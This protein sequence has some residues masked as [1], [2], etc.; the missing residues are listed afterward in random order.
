MDPVRETDGESLVRADPPAVDVSV[1]IVSEAP[2]LRG[3]RR[4]EQAEQSEKVHRR[5]SVR[6]TSSRSY[7]HDGATVSQLESWEDEGGQTPLAAAPLPILIIDNDVSSASS[8]ELMLHA[9]GYPETRVAYSG[10]AALAIAADFEPAVVLLEVDLLDVN[11][12]AL[13]QALR[14]RART[15]KLRLI[16]LTTRRGHEG[17]ELARVAGFER[18]LLKP[19]AALDLSNLLKM[20]GRDAS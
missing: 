12:Y 4:F 14:E 5:E 8:L 16:A 19:V 1:G 6:R 2:I 7:T 9:A 17:R 18:Y 15:R 13:A 11:G 3:E 20:P 10:H